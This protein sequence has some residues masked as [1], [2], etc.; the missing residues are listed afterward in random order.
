MEFLPFHLDLNEV[1]H[2]IF[3]S[4]QTNVTLWKSS[5]LVSYINLFN[6]ASA[7]LSFQGALLQAES[8]QSHL[9]K[10]FEYFLVKCVPQQSRALNFKEGVLII[11]T[12]LIPKHPSVLMSLSRMKQFVH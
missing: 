12:S 2:K 5:Q 10:H 8:A 7:V 4:S 3:G 1:L 9:T 6:I 11:E